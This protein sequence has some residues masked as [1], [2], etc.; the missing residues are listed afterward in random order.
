[1]REQIR[2]RRHTVYRLYC[3][4]GYLMKLLGGAAAFSM[5]IMG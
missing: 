2:T 4:S 1:M 5:E 3:N